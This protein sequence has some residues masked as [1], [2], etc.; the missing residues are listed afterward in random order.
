MRLATERDLPLLHRFQQRT[1]HFGWRTIDFVSKHDVGK[2]GA[3]MRFENARL[4]P[5]NLSPDEVARNRSG[6][7]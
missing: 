6:V 5:V 3:S 7:N 1:L 4:V 2:N